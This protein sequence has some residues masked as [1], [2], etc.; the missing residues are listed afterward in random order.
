MAANCEI[1]ND[2]GQALSSQN[3]GAIDGNGSQQCKLRVQ[4]VGNAAATS[5]QLLVQRLASNDGLD[6]AQLAE[7]LNGNPGTFS[8]DVINV[9]TMQPG[10]IVYF[11]AKVAVPANTTPAGNPRQFSLAVNYTG[12]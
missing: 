2:A 6:F 9:G 3:F 10:D 7:D 1:Q 11:W 8:Q 5:V 4:N 12:T